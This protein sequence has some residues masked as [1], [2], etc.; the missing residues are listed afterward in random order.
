MPQLSYVVRNFVLDRLQD[1]ESGWVFWWGQVC[2]AFGLQPITQLTLGTN[3]FIGNL[4][5]TDVDATGYGVYPMA[6]VFTSKSSNPVNQMLTPTEFSGT[7]QVVVDFWTSFVT[8][9]PPP[10]PESFIDCIED[11]FVET[12]NR[13]EY[14][15]LVPSGVVYNND[16]SEQRFDLQSGGEN[17]LQLTRFAL[18]YRMISQ[19]RANV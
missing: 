8:P 13:Q 3:L 17:W 2:G 1:Q 18:N 4:K 14:Y 7:I 5:A 10:D 6:F 9:S 12:F 16:F 15:G 11:A 19:G